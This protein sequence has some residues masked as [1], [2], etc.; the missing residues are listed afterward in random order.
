MDEQRIIGKFGR[1]YIAD[2]MTYKMG[3]NVRLANHLAARFDGRTV[4]ETCTGGGFSAIALAGFARHVY[5]FEIDCKRMEAAWKN[6]VTAGVDEKIS[7]VNHDVMTYDFRELK[8]R[9]DAAFLDPDWADT[10]PGHVYRFLNS[11]TKPPS[12][13]L[14]EMVFAIT[15][16]V[17][18]VQP[19]FIDPSEFSGLPPHEL[20][21][22]HLDGSFE[23]YCLHFGEL[24]KVAGQTAYKA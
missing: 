1:A 23:L 17:T 20:E 15:P 19:P 16:N 13:K 21:L 4:L 10:G 5:T 24:A 8:G 11:T 12:D 18:L 7:F 3:I 2:D 6:A 14:L 9:L 22:L